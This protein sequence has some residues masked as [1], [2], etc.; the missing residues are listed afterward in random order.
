[1]HIHLP[2]KKKKK[3]W[4]KRT[5]RNIRNTRKFNF[6]G[7]PCGCTAGG[8]P[9]RT[10]HR[11]RGLDQ[12]RPWSSALC[13]RSPGHKA[14]VIPT[15]GWQAPP[16]PGS[17]PPPAGFLGDWKM[18][19]TSLT[20]EP[21]ASALFGGFLVGEGRSLSPALRREHFKAP[22]STFMPAGVSH[23]AP[24]LCPH[25]TLHGYGGW[26]PRSAP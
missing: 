23:P 13:A 12:N 14:R 2:K 22:S 11:R 10:A 20:R 25:Q 18:A 19:P 6:P 1:M 16:G 9:A 15:T 3:E 26:P 21:G 7:E 5:S 17:P 8:S 4:S 24:A